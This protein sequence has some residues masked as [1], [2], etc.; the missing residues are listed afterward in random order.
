M[1]EGQ[2]FGKGERD[3]MGRR[4][5]DMSLYSGARHAFGLVTEA[6]SCAERRISSADAPSHG[7]GDRADHHP[8]LAGAATDTTLLRHPL[9]AAIRDDCVLDRLPEDVSC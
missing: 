3:R 1:L 4:C 8:G 9:A 6:V 2:K 5:S 7:T